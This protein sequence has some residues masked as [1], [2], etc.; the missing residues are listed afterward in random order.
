[1]CH[2]LDT[3]ICIFLRRARPPQVRVRR[4]RLRPDSVGLMLIGGAITAYSS[5]GAYRHG[6]FGDGK[7]HFMA[8]LD[9]ILE[10]H[11]G[12]RAIPEP[13]PV[14]ASTTDGGRA[15]DS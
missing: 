1:M 5:A 2:L 7:S 11:I 13:A 9:P 14:V 4:A 8:V 6:S 10:G 3:N 12:A 15:E